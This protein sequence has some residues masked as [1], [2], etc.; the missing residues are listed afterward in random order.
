MR[1]L[2]MTPIWPS[3]AHPSAG[4]FIAN[5][6]RG[7]PG[8]RVVVDRR[9]GTRWLRWLLLFIWDGLRVR[10]PL[11]GVEAHILYTAGFAGLVVARL[12]RV[13]LLAYA[14]GTDVRQYPQ[15]RRGYR[16]FVRQ[17]VRH[18]DLLVTNSQDTVHLIDAIAADIGRRRA[19]VRVLPPGYDDQLFRPTPRAADRRGKVLYLGGTNPRK[20]PEVAHELA[21]TLVGPGLNEVTP[22]EVARLIAEHDIVLVPSHAEPFG[23]VAAEAIGSGRWVVAR[24]VG[25]LR[26]IVIDGVNGTLVADGDFAGALGRV[27]DYDPFQVARSVERYS[28]TAWQAA[29]RAA[30][31]ELLSARAR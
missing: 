10:G 9:R 22:A 4:I 12:R 15:R 30:W 24:E 13:P 5:R 1:L 29:M 16:F 19:P 26:D 27:P 8:I 3:R 14:H 25:G 17:V 20:A 23:L 18:A 7:V 6:V 28:L 2:V 31:E 11:D 21:D